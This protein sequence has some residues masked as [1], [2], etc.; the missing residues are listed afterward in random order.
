MTLN[1]IGFD[2]TVGETPWAQLA[3]WLGLV[4]CQSGYHG[5][6]NVT[7]KTGANQQVTV[8]AGWRYAKGVLVQ[9]TTDTI[10]QLPVATVSPKWHIIVMH[11]DWTPSVGGTVTF[12]YQ[13]GAGATT[14]PSPWQ[15]V[16]FAG[17]NDNPGTLYDYPLALVRVS[18]GVAVPDRVIPLAICQE[19]A[20]TGW[21]SWNDLLP[22]KADST[23]SY[24]GIGYPPSFRFNLDYTRCELVGRLTRVAGWLDGAILFTLPP[25]ATPPGLTTHSAGSQRS[26]VTLSSELLLT[27]AGVCSA[28][29]ASPGNWI[30][31]DGFVFDC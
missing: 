26:G 2:G 12:T 24:D 4:P 29:N 6:L 28:N 13:G 14:Q 16:Q 17:L 19:Q 20:R 9:S 31:V 15:A 1:A 11:L 18:P 7:A 22:Y 10:V 30:S 5:Q 23:V 25:E 21:R 8:P 3:D 27:A